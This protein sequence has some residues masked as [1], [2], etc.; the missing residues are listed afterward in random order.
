MKV[1]EPELL[2]DPRSEQPWLRGIWTV[3]SCTVGYWLG[4]WCFHLLVHPNVN[5]VSSG[6]HKTHESCIQQLEA[7]WIGLQL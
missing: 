1:C 7:S 6:S 3:Y 4:Y 5:A 2:A